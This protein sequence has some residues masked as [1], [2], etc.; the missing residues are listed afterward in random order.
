VS[1]SNETDPVSDPGG[2]ADEDWVADLKAEG[3]ARDIALRRLHDILLRASRHQ[4]WRL[5]GMLPH[6]SSDD[7]TDLAMQIADEATVAVL[8][9]LDSFE[10]R[11][12]FA[13]WA[14]KFAVYQAGVEVRK[15]AWRSRELSLSDHAPLV[16]MIDPDSSPAEVLEATEL[17][18]AVEHAIATALTP[19]QRRIAV[20]L[21]VEE[22]PI[23]V[24]AER[25]GTTRNALYKTLHDAR[26]RLRAALIEGGQLDGAG[27]RSSA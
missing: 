5:R 19:H 20:A 25:L 18:R 8:R 14:Y 27:G 1:R 6:A 23:D 22:V 11:S 15:Q 9:R 12:K 24:L 10:G 21:V 13:T 3:P 26:Q 16:G 4:V 2:P 17:A 7:L